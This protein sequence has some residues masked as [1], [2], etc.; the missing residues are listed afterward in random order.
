MLLLFCFTVESSDDLNVSRDGAGN[1]TY[2]NKA[3]DQTVISF[4]DPGASNVDIRNRL[5]N[6][7]HPKSIY[8]LDRKLSC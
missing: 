8:R 6:S 5:V 7:N 4:I 2:E 1:T 3:N